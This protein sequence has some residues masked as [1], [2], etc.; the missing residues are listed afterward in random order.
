MKKTWKRIACLALA[1][2][3]AFPFV[4]CTEEQNYDPETHPFT[5][6]TDALDGNFNPFFATSGPDV[7]IAGHTQLSMMSTDSKGQPVCGQNEATVALDYKETMKDASGNVTTNGDLAANGGS[8][9]YEFVLK[10]GI[11]F[12]D[13]DDLTLEDVLFNLYV[14]LDP[15]YMGSATIYSTKIKGLNAYRKQDASAS[16]DGG[17]DQSQFY[18]AADTRLA[19]MQQYCSAST[20]DNEYS[21]SDV[22][23]ILADIATA[24]KFF[25]DE[26]TTDWTETYGTLESYEEKYRFTE[27]WEVFYFNAGLVQVAYQKQS[28]GSYKALEDSEGR[29]YTNLDA[30]VDQIQGA[31]TTYN[32]TYKEDMDAALTGL[33]GQAK[34]D[35]MKEVAI[36]TVYSGMVQENYINP[37][38]LRYWGTG[39]ELREEF[40]AEARSDF[41]EEIFG[42]SGILVDHIEGISYYKTS[43]FNGKMGEKLDGEHD[44][45]KIV[46]DGVDPKA[47]WNFAFTVSPM[48]YYGN[49]ASGEYENYATKNVNLYP[50]AGEKYHFGVAFG[51]KDYFDTVLKDPVKNGLPVGAGAYM[52]CSQDKTSVATRDNFYKDNTVYFK[53]NTYFDTVGTGIE[54]A[55]IKYLEYKVTSSDMI[56]GRL[57]REE[58]LYGQPNATPQ[59]VADLGGLNATIAS[60]YYDT[61]GYGYVGVNP[62]Y[63]PDITIRR[64]IMRAMDLDYPISYYGSLAKTIYRSMSSSSDY[65]PKRNEDGDA[66]MNGTPV[67]VYTGRADLFGT[68]D[69][70]LTSYKLQGM[71]A[72][73]VTEEDLT[74]NPDL[75]TDVE[76]WIIKEIKKELDAKGWASKNDA[77]I[78]VNS[79]GEKLEYVFT[80]AGDT[81]DHPAY[82]MFENAATILNQC[83]FKITVTN[84][85]TALSKLTSGKLQV[86]AAAWQSTIDPDMYQV[87]HRDSTATS[88]KN[89]GYDEI[90]DQNNGTRFEYEQNII[91]KLSDDYIEPARQ[92]INPEQRFEYYANALDYVMELAVELPTYQRKDLYAYNKNVIDASTL[93]T[94]PNGYSGVLDRIWEVNYL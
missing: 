22:P 70:N 80:I 1:G 71:A 2:L 56:I 62:T 24:Q 84:D 81:T 43:S 51:D 78:R 86:W 42:D 27:L 75:F 77:G 34:E 26:V 25:K 18:V 21:E 40:A 31:T 28:N 89:W 90:F 17:F 8:T 19:Y 57:S 87:Y 54:D 33:R 64:I 7:S 15:A 47:I 67:G 76:A 37:D 93:N 13:G 50:E 63:V 11:K 30:E 74:N 36:N 48:H 53:R 16:N 41:Y 39:D 92:T 66:D 10:K 55:K 83:G 32:K 91:N 38:V 52:A 61:N 29:Y 3:T 82:A 69:G 73:G 9:E 23:Q 44:V 45:L 85:L 72:E 6:S 58:I 35:K 68:T 46:I 60:D 94:S 59:N 65:Y 49:A 12:S 20:T 79:R 88:V 14:Y 4:G 5:L